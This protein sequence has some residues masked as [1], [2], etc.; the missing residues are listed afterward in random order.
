MIES[1][2]KYKPHKHRGSIEFDL[3]QRQFFVLHNVGH[4]TFMLYLMSITCTP[5]LKLVKNGCNMYKNL[6]IHILS[7]YDLKLL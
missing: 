5:S 3:I 6:L 1:C 2:L 7:V 4:Y